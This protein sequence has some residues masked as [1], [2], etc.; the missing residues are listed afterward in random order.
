VSISL[1]ADGKYLLASTYEEFFI[2]ELLDDHA[3]MIRSEQR[4]GNITV[5]SRFDVAANAPLAAF[6][7]RDKMTVLEIPSAR[8]LLEIHPEGWMA[9]SPD[10]RL[11]ATTEWE[12]HSVR[13]YQ[14]PQ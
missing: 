4:P 10:G 14:V 3:E 2:F 9:V 6:M 7:E 12:R 5:F 1:T 8:S 11:V 13:I